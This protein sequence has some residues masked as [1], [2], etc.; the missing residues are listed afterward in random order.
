VTRLPADAGVSWRVVDALGCIYPSEPW[1]APIIEQEPSQ[2][3]RTMRGMLR[4]PVSSRPKILK[5]RGLCAVY[6]TFSRQVPDL[7]KSEP[8]I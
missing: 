8:L 6:P 1:L 7:L 2:G 5:L 3:L 4:S